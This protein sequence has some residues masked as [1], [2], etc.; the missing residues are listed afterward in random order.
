MRCSLG[1]FWANAML[2]ELREVTYI[3][4]SAILPHSTDLLAI[5]RVSL[6]YNEQ[7]EISGFLYFDSRYFVQ[8][9][10]GTAAELGVLL[11]KIG[12]DHRHYDMI[13]LRDTSIS[14]RRFERWRMAFCDGTSGHC[15][16]GFQAGN[17]APE[18]ALRGAAGSLLRAL[19]SL[20]TERSAL[21][22][23]R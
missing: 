20:D 12:S 5:A 3:S 14:L 6:R 10:E 13:V 2:S 7:K 11:Q 18:L 17:Y 9:L 8:I 4:R 16:F 23:P 22:L 15:L 19:D 1:G 21:A